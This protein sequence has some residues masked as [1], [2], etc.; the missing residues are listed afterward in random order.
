MSLVDHRV[1]VHSMKIVYSDKQKLHSPM[2]EWNFGK[3]VPYPEKEKRLEVILKTLKKRGYDSNIIK[4]RKYSISHILKVHD[5]RMVK[6]IKSCADLKDGE[7]I[8]AH[9]F[10]YRV[11]GAHP[12]TNLR[13]AGYFC[14]DVGTQIVKH[15]YEAAKTAVDCSLHGAELILNGKENVVFALTRPP[16][17][18]ADHK[19]YGGY[20]YF[21]N[22]AIAASHMSLKGRVVV[23]DLDFHHG[24]GTQSIFYETPNVY[25][26]SIHGNPANHYP[27]CCGFK[28]ERGA[29]LGEGLNLNIPLPTGTGD[30]EYRIKLKKIC[31]IISR[32]KPDYLVLSVGFDTFKDDPLGDFNLTSPFYKEMGEIFVS[33]GIPL[34]A[35]LEGGYAIKALG[36]NVAN[37]CD[38]LALSEKLITRRFLT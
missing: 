23:V 4:P 13:L 17:H 11:Y 29:K 15:T 14:F 6:H 5:K 30:N 24:N 22:A 28:N 26:I 33:L 10:P 37:F 38:G 34:L 18:H 32:W 31:R 3:S 9:V 2:R 36:T 35:C 7:A 8:H 27:Y 25:F 19:I 20:C 12:K 16:G 21:N 1:R